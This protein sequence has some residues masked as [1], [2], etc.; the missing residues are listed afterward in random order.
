MNLEKPKYAQKK[1]IWQGYSLENS[2][3]HVIQIDS[4]RR[5]K[6]FVNES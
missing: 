6:F 2:A 1:P 4:K 5:M 3:D